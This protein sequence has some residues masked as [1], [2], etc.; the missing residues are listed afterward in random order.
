MADSTALSRLILETKAMKLTLL[1]DLG[2]SV[3]GLT[4][5]TQDILRPFARTADESPLQTGGFPL[6]P[7]SGR[8]SEGRFVWNGHAVSLAPNFLPEPHA[9]HG[10][11]WHAAW[12]VAEHGS[13]HAR[14]VFDY[15]PGDWPW[16]YRA[17]QDFTLR[18][19]GLDLTLR[20]TNQSEDPMPAGLGWHPYFPRMDARVTVPVDRVW[21]SDEGMIPDRLDVPAAGADVSDWRV[22]DELDLDNAFT[23]S[24]RLSCIEWP[25]RNLRVEMVS[26]AVLGHMVI[27]TPKGQ[28]FFC[29]EPVSHAPDAVNS[30][31]PAELTGLH[32]LAPGETLSA[33]ISLTIREA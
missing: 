33:R 10:Q 27:Y 1:P 17:E 15:R 5:K 19:D 2:G 21:T 25:S 16:A 9:I 4:Y 20:L 22:V 7:F 29:V 28:D 14:L 13:D 26:D 18:E 24:D 12:Q 30:Q 6:F 3:G 32:S 8:I 11:A 23:V 31:H